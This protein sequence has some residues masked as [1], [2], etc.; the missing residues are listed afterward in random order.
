VPISLSPEPTLHLVLRGSHLTDHAGEIAFPGGKPEAADASLRATAGRE[1]FEEVGVSED[2][3]EWLGELSPCPV[4]TGRYVIHPFVA[5]LAEGA[6]PRVAS[7]EIAEVLSLPIGPYV[8]GEQPVRAIEVP[9]RGEKVLAPHFPIGGRTLYGATAYIT[10]ELLVR[11]AAALGRELP[12]P[13]IEDAAPWG[14]RYG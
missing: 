4:I 1:L 11:L 3:L 8:A 13:V 2:E 7:G 10:W 9:W 12:S 5:L 6:A 14:K